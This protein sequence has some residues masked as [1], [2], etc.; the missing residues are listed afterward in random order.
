MQ[1]FTCGIGRFV[2][3]AVCLCVASSTYGH[4]D[5]NPEPGTKAEAAVSVTW[6]DQGVLLSNG[7]WQIP[8]VL[9]GGEAYPV[10]E[11]TSVDEARVGVY[12]RSV[13]D[14]FGYLQVSSHA[15]G[16]EAELHHAFAG[17][18]LDVGPLLATIVAGRMAAA[19][20]PA[21]G[22]HASDRLFSETPL[23]LDAFLGRQLNDEGV[24]LVWSRG[25]LQLGLESWRGTAFPATPGEGGGSS[26][27]YIHVGDQHG[28]LRYHAGLWWLQAD[29]MNRQDSRY[30]ADGLQH[31]G[32]ALVVAPEYWF[33]GNT[34]MAGAFVRLDWQWTVQTALNV[35]A[36]WLQVNTAGVLRDATRRADLDADDNGGWLQASV[37][38]GNHQWGLRWEQLVVENELSGAAAEAMAIETQLYNQGHN[39][40]R[41]SVVYRWQLH[42]DVAVRLEAVDDQIQSEQQQR[43]AVGMVWKAAL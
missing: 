7:W 17:L 15:G 35:D 8:G 31:G 11:G 34:E 32:A 5:L 42:P 23:A 30:S 37:R 33:D 38:H 16:Q 1:L 36:Q 43:F 12:H 14:V 41:A 22:E 4:G 3:V 40:N 2:L 26:D 39:P 25:P 27:A 10:E 21:N 29:A 18:D 24:R 19:M 6:R 9:M 28:A 13:H 20:T